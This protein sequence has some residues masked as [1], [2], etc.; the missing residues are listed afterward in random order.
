MEKSV[1]KLMKNLSKEIEVRKS[2][3]EPMM[4]LSMTN[5]APK[6]HHNKKNEP[7]HQDILQSGPIARYYRNAYHLL[8]Y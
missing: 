3:I 8:P 1:I 6:V 5:A 4:A 7:L 2:V